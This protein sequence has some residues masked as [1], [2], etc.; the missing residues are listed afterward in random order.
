MKFLGDFTEQE[1]E[2]VRNNID[3]VKLEDDKEG[4]FIGDIN[5]MVIKDDDKSLSIK[6]ITNL[7]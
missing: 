4:L 6:K 3:K 1:K 7:I 2:Y 5:F